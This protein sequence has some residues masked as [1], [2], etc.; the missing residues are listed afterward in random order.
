MK[1]MNNKALTIIS[2]FT[3]LAISGCGGGS[4]SGGSEEKEVPDTLNVVTLYGPISYFIYRGQEMG[5]HYENVRQFAEQNNMVLNLKVASNM[6][7]MLSALTDGEADVAAY[8]VPRIWEYSDSVIY[9]GQKEVTWQVLVQPGG[10]DEIDD[11][12]SL[13]GRDVYVEKDSKYHYRINN[14]NAEL[15]GGIEI[16]PISRDTLIT[17]DL[18]EMVH[19]GE[20]PMT[21]VDSDI[22][23]LCH[24][25]YPDLDVDMKVSLDQ[26]SSWAVGRVDTLLAAKIDRWNASKEHTGFSKELYRKY[27]ELSRVP[28][29]G[30]IIVAEVRSDGSVSPYDEHFRR[31]AGLS[32]YPWQLLAAIGFAES[33][34]KPGVR[35]WAGA[36]GIMQVMPSTA[37][38]LGFSESDLEDVGV[39]IRAGAT[40]VAKLDES[41][42]KMI[43]DSEERI[44]FVLAA[45]NSG[46]GHV[47]DAIALAEKYGYNPKVWHGNVSNAMLMKSKPQYYNDSVVKNGYSRGRETLEFVETVMEA[48]RHYTSR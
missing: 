33:R 15:G 4:G 30:D 27:F 34:F 38:S 31:Y 6:K 16:H 1:N 11:V 23:A 35:S 9:C 41:L 47:L 43:A 42:K 46:L 17:E 37:R 8:P 39:N 13:V 21:I 18:V 32:G 45:Y 26:L 20:I 48:Y 40:L 29:G 7:E 25:Y 2:A 24:G 28:E 14:L 44:K 3:M 10:G 19:T 36:R 5:Y 12:T 22:A